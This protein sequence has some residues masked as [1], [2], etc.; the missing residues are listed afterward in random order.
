MPE[1]STTP[2]LVERTRDLYEISNRGD[3]DAMMTFYAPDVVWDA[4]P[5]V[6]N[7]FEGMATFRG[8]AQDYLA[9]FEDHEWTAEVLVDLGGGVV[10][11]VA[12]QKARPKGSTGYVHSREGWVTEWTDGLITRVTTYSDIDEARAVAERLAQELADA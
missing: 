2:D 6:G 4:S 11:A 3:I 7:V 1:E 12:T 9:A 5:T 10:F 8:F